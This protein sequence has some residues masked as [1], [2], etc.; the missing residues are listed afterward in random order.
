MTFRLLT[1]GD[2]T[3]SCVKVLLGDGEIML[4]TDKVFRAAQ[5]SAGPGTTVLLNS[6]GGIVDGGLRLGR[7]FRETRSTVGVAPG[8]RCYS[9]CA[10]ALLGGVSRSVYSGADYGVHQSIRVDRKPG[11][12]P[13]AADKASLRE[14]MTKLRKYTKDMGVNADLLDLVMSTSHEDIRVL[15]SKELTQMRVVTNR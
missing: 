12:P 4:G 5:R 11:A 10:Y 8:G 9:S 15:D 7:A 3:A 13:T 2:C 6:P 1:V 14:V